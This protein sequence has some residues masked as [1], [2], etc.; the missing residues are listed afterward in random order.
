MPTSSNHAGTDELHSA[1]TAHVLESTE[2]WPMSCARGRTAAHKR[3]VGLVRYANSFLGL[4][5]SYTKK[6]TFSPFH[7]DC[8]KPY[9]V[10]NEDWY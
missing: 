1:K 5:Y 4:F 8:H 6:F 9:N 2:S 10:V 7:S 3:N